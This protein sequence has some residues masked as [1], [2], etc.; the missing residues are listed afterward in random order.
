MNHTGRCVT[1]SPRQAARN[2][3]PVR[4]GGAGIGATLPGLAGAVPVGAACRAV[5][6]HVLFDLDGTIADSRQGIVRSLQFGFEACGLPVP[7]ES[8]LEHVIG[9]PLSIALPRFGIDDDTVGRVIAAYRSR[10][11]P[12][13]I[14][15][16]ELYPGVRD[17]L[18]RLADAGFT[19]AI[20]T[21]KP[22]PFAERIVE[23]FDL[24]RAFAVVA[25][26]TF[27]DTR[28][29]KEDV[30][31]HA[32][33][34]LPGATAANTLMVGDRHH[35]IEGARAHGLRAI[36]VTWGFGDHAELDGAGAWQLADVADDVERFV[37]GV[38]GR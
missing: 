19:L 10:Y 15:E 18:Y 2:V 23:H 27:D 33:A 32:L 21:S 31:A 4:V 16:A 8:E 28:S 38:S 17:M 1:A 20:A 25:G 36:G 22:E 7:P 35:D 37:L 11:R 5:I 34:Q 13:G 12:I 26:A 24:A 30:I 9:P 6:T 3:D 14:F 29:L